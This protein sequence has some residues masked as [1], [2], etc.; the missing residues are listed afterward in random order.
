MKDTTWEFHANFFRKHGRLK[1][2]VS[3]SWLSQRPSLTKEL[4]IEFAQY[5]D[6]NLIIDH[7]IFELEFITELQ[8]KG[9][10]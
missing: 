9:Y 4:A 1:P 8:M 6:W 5:L 7:G 10:I 2:Y 3:W